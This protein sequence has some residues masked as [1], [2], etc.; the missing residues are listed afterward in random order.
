MSLAVH[1]AALF[2]LLMQAVPP[3]TFTGTF[4]AIE[5]GHVVVEVENS[6]TI[7]MFITSGTKFV[8]D[9]KKAK[10]SDFHDGDAVEVDAERDAR[11][12]MVAKRVEAVKPVPPAPP[13][14]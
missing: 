11:M 14:Q 12:N 6:Q 5:S 10:P 3:A 13:P 2:T 4:R 9:G 7:R 8:R 1:I